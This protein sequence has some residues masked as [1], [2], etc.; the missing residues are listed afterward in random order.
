MIVVDIEA[1]GLDA[2]ES[3]IVSVGAIGF[4]NPENQFYEECRI[5]EG[6]HV[7][8]DSLKV[9]GFT[10]EQI[11]DPKKKTD[12]EVVEAFLA[13]SRTCKEWT[14]AGQNPSF[15]RDF[16]KET[17]YRY[18]VNWPIAHR[19]VDLHSVAYA[20]FVKKGI[21]IPLKNNHSD[22]DLDN[23]AKFVGLTSEPEP[24]N[25]LNGAKFAA[26]ALSRLLNGKQL[27]DEYKEFAIPS[28]I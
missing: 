15:D 12:R 20:H 18:H 19:T 22:L 23:I 17:A 2:K 4:N 27:L 13:W 28:D 21:E 16:L 26:E 7:N 11:R 3:S 5:F 1:S 14:L 8:E 9:N 25:A 24:H 6:A 10:E